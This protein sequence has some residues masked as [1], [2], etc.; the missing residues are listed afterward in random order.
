MAISALLQALFWVLLG[1]FS[2]GASPGQVHPPHSGKLLWSQHSHPLE[3]LNPCEFATE[4][5]SLAN[6]LPEPCL[7]PARISS[8][9]WQVAGCLPLQELPIAPPGFL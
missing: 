5:K 8:Q 9:S 1:L 2:L 4:G 7:S 6:L 3:T